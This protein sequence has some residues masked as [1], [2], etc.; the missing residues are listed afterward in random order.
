[1]HAV[2]KLKRKLRQ[3]FASKSNITFD[4]L[5]DIEIA[6]NVFL[7]N[8]LVDSILLEYLERL[9]FHLYCVN[10]FHDI[11]VLYFTHLPLHYIEIDF[12]NFDFSSLSYLSY[13][14]CYYTL[15]PAEVTQIYLL[16][17][18]EYK[19]RKYDNFLKNNFPGGDFTFEI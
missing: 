11:P 15:M 8:V 14:H 18:I 10:Y 3:F 5:E 2:S 6:S 12:R 7:P 16:E 19:M 9:N 1:M 17:K 13:I 4:F